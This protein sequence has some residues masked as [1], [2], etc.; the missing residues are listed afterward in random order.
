MLYSF[1]GSFRATDVMVINPADAVAVERVEDRA[2]TRVIDHPGEHVVDEAICRCGDQETP[3]WE[4]RAEARSST[5]GRRAG[6][7]GRARHKTGDRP[8]P[9]SPSRP[10]APTW[11]GRGRAAC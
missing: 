3:V 4:S 1:Y 2:S 11:H 8:L 7:S 5:N 6:K 10:G 9:S